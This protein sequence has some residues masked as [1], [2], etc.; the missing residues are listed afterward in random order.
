MTAKDLIEKLK[1]LAPDDRVSIAL[2]PNFYEPEY[3]GEP[4][5]EKYDCR[6][7]VISGQIQP[8]SHR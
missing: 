8:G 7:F 2:Y 1:E 3:L 5:I 6:H 4:E